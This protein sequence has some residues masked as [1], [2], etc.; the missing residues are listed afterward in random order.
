MF[1]INRLSV[2]ILVSFK[3]L[4]NSLNELN[5]PDVASSSAESVCIPNLLSY[6]TPSSYY[7]D[8]IKFVCSNAL[9]FKS[10]HILPTPFSNHLLL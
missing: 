3:K 6:F 2:V 4:I 7:A 1:V 5:Q 9:K 10:G 8:V